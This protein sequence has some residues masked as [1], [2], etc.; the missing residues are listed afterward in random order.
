MKCVRG[1]GKVVRVTDA[2]A[3]MLVS[4]KGYKYVPKH[5]WKKEGRKYG[6]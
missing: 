1:N 6:K 2:K 3:A 4:S 5:E